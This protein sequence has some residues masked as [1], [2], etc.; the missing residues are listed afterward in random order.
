MWYAMARLQ[1]SYSLQERLIRTIADWRAHSTDD[2]EDLLNDGADVNG[3]SGTLLP[4]HCACMVKD[5]T[6]LKLLLQRGALVNAVDG[7]ERTA[8]H[9][10]AEKDDICTELLIEYGADVNSPDGNQ[11]TPLH[12]AAFKNNVDCVKILL[13]NNAAVNIGDFNNDTPISWAAFKCNVESVQLLLEYGADPAITNYNEMSPI[14]RAA[15]MAASGLETKDPDCVF[16][17]IKGLGQFDI[18]NEQGSLPVEIK[19]DPELY[20]LLMNY[21]KNV[22]PLKELCRYVIR[23]SLGQTFLPEAVRKL[24]LPAALQTYLLLQVH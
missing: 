21:S 22:R 8:L 15:V 19:R 7:Y 2:V 6:V 9:Y 20:N 3:A 16:L 14:K 12:W 1:Q 13:Q 18:R 23:L 10:A 17:L 4:L 24:P 11:D 5:S